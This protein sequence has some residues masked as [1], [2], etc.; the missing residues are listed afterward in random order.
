MSI[1]AYLTS[2]SIS[3]YMFWNHAYTTTTY[4]MKRLS[5]NSLQSDVPYVKLSKHLP[6]YHFLKVRLLHF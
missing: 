5:T 3:P 6:E 4:L 1:R 2:Q